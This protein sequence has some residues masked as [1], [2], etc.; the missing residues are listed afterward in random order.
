[1]DEVECNLESFGLNEVEIAFAVNLAQPLKEGDVDQFLEIYDS[2]PAS[3]E[4]ERV[5]KRI[6]LPSERRWRCHPLSKLL[7]FDSFSELPSA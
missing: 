6:F 2:I 1:M 4:S 5:S 7:S 3:V